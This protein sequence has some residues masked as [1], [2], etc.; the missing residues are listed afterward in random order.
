MMSAS[1]LDL[2]PSSKRKR[3][4]GRLRFT[5]AGLLALTSL[6]AVWMPTWINWRR[7]PR[8]RSQSAQIV[9]ASGRLTIP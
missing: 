1:N 3:R 8:L 2:I 7:L 5:L 4:S 6:V 9:E